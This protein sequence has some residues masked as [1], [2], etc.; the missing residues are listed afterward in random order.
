MSLQIDIANDLDA[1]F[2]ADVST[3]ASI[4]GKEITGHLTKADSGFGMD[5]ETYV[6]DAAAEHLKDVRRGNPVTIGGL[7]YQVVRPDF[8]GDRTHLVL[9]L[10]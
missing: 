5:A 7:V 2:Y 10:V 6:F 3:V 4:S 8:Q 1:V 9:A